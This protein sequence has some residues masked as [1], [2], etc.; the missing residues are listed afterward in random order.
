MPSSSRSRGSRRFRRQ[1][2][3]D[4]ANGMPMDALLEIF[5]CLD[6]ADVLLA[7]GCVC[8]AWRR[9]A[10]DKPSLWRRIS[11]RCTEYDGLELAGLRSY[12]YR[13][14]RAALRR[15]AGKC[16]VFSFLGSATDRGVVQDAFLAYL[17][18]QAPRLKSL[19]LVSC[20]GITNKGLITAVRGLPQLKELEM[21]LCKKIGDSRVFKAFLKHVHS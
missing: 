2:E 9:A 19:R 13:L 7:A 6:H 10:R 12:R 5:H 8:R 17:S 11:I 1:A 20:N 16:E 14:A 4:W 3:R 18:E 21:S 15:S